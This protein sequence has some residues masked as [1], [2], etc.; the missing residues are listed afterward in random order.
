MFGRICEG[1]SW[2]TNVTAV[3]N[4]A[5]AKDKREKDIRND[6]HL[7]ISKTLEGLYEVKPM[8]IS[9]EETEIKKTEHFNIVPVICDL[10]VKAHGGDCDEAF[11]DAQGTVEAVELP[12]GVA[13]ESATSTDCEPG[14]LDYW[15][16][17]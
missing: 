5:F 9:S 8:D 4:V 12:V 1:R 10:R 17:R 14:D 11:L 6:A 16:E 7:T 15:E 3:F 13:L 2:E